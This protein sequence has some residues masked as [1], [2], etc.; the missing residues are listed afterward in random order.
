MDCVQKRK[1]ETTSPKKKINPRIFH[2]ILKS[3]RS[4]ETQS[5]KSCIIS[6]WSTDRSW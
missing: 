4:G 2:C 5:I 1:I 6:S 3:T